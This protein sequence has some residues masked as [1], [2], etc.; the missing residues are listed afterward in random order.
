M[1]IQSSEL[2]MASHLE[3]LNQLTPFDGFSMHQ[4]MRQGKVSAPNIYNNSETDT[5]LA[6][7]TT[8]VGVTSALA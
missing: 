7:N 2:V 8:S 1:F 3:L 5:A 6:V 4:W